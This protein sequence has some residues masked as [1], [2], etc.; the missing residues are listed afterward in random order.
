MNGLRPCVRTFGRL[1]IQESRDFEDP[2]PRTFSP[3]DSRWSL[4]TT[5]RVRCSDPGTIVPRLACDTRWGVNRQLFAQYLGLQSHKLRSI[6]PCYSLGCQQSI[7]RLLNLTFRLPANFTVYHRRNFYFGAKST[8]FV[9]IVC[10][11][12]LIQPISVQFGLMSLSVF[13]LVSIFVE[14]RLIS[15]LASSVLFVHRVADSLLPCHRFRTDGCVQFSGVD[16]PRCSFVGVVRALCFRM[17][18]ISSTR[19]TME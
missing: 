13:L 11:D 4:Q 5:D 7:E 18:I 6:A 1:R 14:T 2:I 16:F 19:L 10:R 3:F 15:F 17:A 9:L 12:D 8:L